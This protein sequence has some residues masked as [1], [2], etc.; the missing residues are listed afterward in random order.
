VLHEVFYIYLRKV[1]SKTLLENEF[2]LK[3]KLTTLRRFI[4][5]SLVKI[6]NLYGVYLSM[7]NFKLKFWKLLNIL[8][9]T[10]NE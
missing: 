6:Q 7:K 8:N 10:R 5:N 3:K 1:V 2:A 4:Y 9:G